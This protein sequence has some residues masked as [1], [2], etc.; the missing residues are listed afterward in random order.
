M[1]GGLITIISNYATSSYAFSNTDGTYVKRSSSLN[2]V[3]IASP[4][5]LP[6]S[7]CGQSAMNCVTDLYSNHGWISI[8]TAVQTAF[9]PQTAVAAA[10]TCVIHIYLL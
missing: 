4:K 1:S 2:N 7:D 9:L 10:A 6:I 8:W 3:L 5:K